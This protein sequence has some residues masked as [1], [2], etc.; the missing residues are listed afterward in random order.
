[1]ELEF[2]IE[3][4]L[5]FGILVRV[6]EDGSERRVISRFLGSDANGFA[7]RAFGFEELAETEFDACEVHPPWP[8][9]GINLN[10]AVNV[11]LGVSVIVKLILRVSEI[12]VGSGVI[13]THVHHL[14][15]YLA[16]DGERF[17]I[18]FLGVHGSEIDHGRDVVGRNLRCVRKEQKIGRPVRLVVEGQ[19]AEYGYESDGDCASA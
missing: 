18:A 12:E 3:F 15:K 8:I 16:G 6:Q 11:L 5:G 14:R 1:M 4:L 7:S 2:D 9:H 13:G 10:G 17:E 19:N